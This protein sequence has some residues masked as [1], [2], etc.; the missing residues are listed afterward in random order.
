MY[1]IINKRTGKYLY[2]TDFRYFPAHQ[3]TSY[4]RAALFEDL[5]MAEYHFKQRHC[6]KDYKIVAVR[7]EV[8]E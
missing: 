3:R 6:G 8:L 5:E 7:L 1:A 4:D 2:G